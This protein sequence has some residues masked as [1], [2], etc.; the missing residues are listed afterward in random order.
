M[1]DTQGGV[2]R[3]P[4]PANHWQDW[5]NLAL[6]VWLFLSPWILG[7]A[8]FSG[9]GPGQAA[10]IN[11]WIVGIIIA[12]LSLAALQRTQPWEEWVNIIAGIWLFISPWVLGYAGLP[13]ALWNALIVGALV[14]IL[15]AWDLGTLRQ[16]A[17]WRAR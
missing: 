15:A 2:H 1:A 11:A 14:F 13:A 4:E 3:A 16:T 12:A 10:S 8:D 5:V 9:A 17:S 6:G 7:F